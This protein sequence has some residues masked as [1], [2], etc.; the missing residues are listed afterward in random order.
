MK[1]L[2]IEALVAL[3]RMRDELLALVPQVGS[4]LHPVLAGLLVDAAERVEQVRTSASRLPTT[5]ELIAIAER[6]RGQGG[7]HG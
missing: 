1:P 5:T 6:R 3:E 2:D 7:K 4:R